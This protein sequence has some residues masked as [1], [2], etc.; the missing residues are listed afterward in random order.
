MPLKKEVNEEI[1]NEIKKKNKTNVNAETMNSKS[2]GCHKSS[3]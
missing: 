1:K 3:A 2:M